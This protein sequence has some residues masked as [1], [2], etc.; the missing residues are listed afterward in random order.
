[1]RYF[2]ADDVVTKARIGGTTKQLSSHVA[3]AA[4]I[5]GN[6]TSDVAYAVAALLNEKREQMRWQ[7]A[8][9]QSAMSAQTRVYPNFLILLNP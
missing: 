7:Y 8:G 1:M 9:R 6:S 3:K 4:G 5:N 2:A